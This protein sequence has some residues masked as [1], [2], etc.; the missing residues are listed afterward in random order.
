[1]P[2]PLFELPPGQVRMEE[3]GSATPNKNSTEDYSVRKT[4]SR[5][6]LTGKREVRPSSRAGVKLEKIPERT[7]QYNSAASLPKHLQG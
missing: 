4:K 3:G 2:R 5:T 6:L 1:M 7:E